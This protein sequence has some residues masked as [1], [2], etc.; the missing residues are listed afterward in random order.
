MG[1]KIAQAAGAA[2]PQ[3]LLLG[4]WHPTPQSPAVELCCCKWGFKRLEEW[5]LVIAG[6]NVW[7]TWCV[8]NAAVPA[9][10]IVTARHGP[11]RTTAKRQYLWCSVTF[12]YFSASSWPPSAF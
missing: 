10:S 7:S 3:T 2:S 4:E 11:S 5:R 6:C 1:L 8:C 9:C 12:S